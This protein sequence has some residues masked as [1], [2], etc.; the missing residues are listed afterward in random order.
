MSGSGSQT[1]LR[2]AADGDGSIVVAYEKEESAIDE[3]AVSVE[4]MV[5]ELGECLPK[6][7]NN[8]DASVTAKN[9]TFLNALCLLEKLPS[10]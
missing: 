2:W 8:S 3:V 9:Y 5:S 6:P 1:P 7:N 4:E 10:S